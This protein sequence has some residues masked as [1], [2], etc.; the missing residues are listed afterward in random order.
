MRAFAAVV[1]AVA[2]SG[3]ADCTGNP[4]PP[5]D[6]GAGG[7]SDGG[8]VLADCNAFV[9]NY[10]GFLGRCYGLASPDECKAGLASFCRNAAESV[11]RGFQTATPGGL[12]ACGR[13]VGPATAC[14][15]FLAASCVP[16]M[17]AVSDGG[18]CLTSNDCTAIVDPTTGFSR[19]AVCGAAP[20]CPS[21]C[22]P[23]GQLGQPCNFRQCASGLRCDNTTNTCSAPL[24]LDAGCNPGT[25]D[26]GVNAQC[27]FNVN[28]CVALPGDGDPC[29]SFQCQPG[30]TC[31]GFANGT[32]GPLRTQGQ[33]CTQFG[34][35]CAAGL[36]CSSG[37]TCEPRGGVGAMC[38]AAD[39]CLADLGCSFG[40]CAARKAQGA[41]CDGLDVRECLGQCDRVLGACVDDDA[42]RPA[43]ATC[44]DRPVCDAG[45]CTGLGVNDDGGLHAGVCGTPVTGG[46]CLTDL[47]VAQCPSGQTCIT[48]DGGVQSGAG[49][50]QPIVAGGPCY[51]G[52]D[53]LATERCDVGQRR[54]RPRLAEGARCLPGECQ[55]GLECPSSTFT[56]TR[57]RAAGESCDAGICQQ[58]MECLA[59]TCQMTGIPGAA[60]R[61][62]DSFLGCGPPSCAIG[63]C[64]VDA[65]RCVRPKV[66]GPCNDDG[67]C[68]SSRCRSHECQATCQ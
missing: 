2:V 55:V 28:R 45:V 25:G 1:L 32:C 61:V 29:P 43:G 11:R 39:D 34:P 38:G 68:E 18:A 66:T 6:G 24:P 35:A 13:I 65:G 52:V 62:C 37:G 21:R 57:L 56:C 19:F 26:C 15:D 50:C 20:G 8:D 48:G 16:V 63:T 3:C 5:P 40:R 64:D 51:G 10:C 4:Q 49:T 27:D 9:N 7:G 60:C 53:C 47:D 44:G 41:P 67:E 42:S 31:S 33:M 12:E 54:C 22:E 23:G 46:A 58:P 14:D 59:G 30:L 36:T 17:P